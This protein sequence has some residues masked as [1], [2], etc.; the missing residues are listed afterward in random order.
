MKIA[1]GI[2]LLMHSIAHLAGFVVPWQLMNN[3]EM[4]YKTTLFA[5]HWD[6]G[7]VGIR[8]I[9]VLWLAV[10]LAFAWAGMSVM[11]MTQGWESITFYVALAS[12][13]LCIVS[14]PEAR[15]GVFVNLVVLLMLV[16]HNN[17]NLLAEK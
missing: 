15:I 1:L 5:G 10:A 11:R 4:P 14:W 8:V 6:V 16:F 13:A 17:I 12:L 9:G 3:T 2:F 7:D